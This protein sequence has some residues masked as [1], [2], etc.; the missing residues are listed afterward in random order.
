M[1]STTLATWAL[2]RGQKLARAGKTDEALAT[3]ESETA[4]GNY[5]LLIHHALTLARAGQADKALEQSAAAAAAAPE[6]GLPAVFNTYLLL[7]SG[8][9][10][11]AEAELNRA[12][13]LLP[14]NPIVSSLSAALDILRGNAVDGC[15]RLLEGPLTDNLDI[16][17]WIMAVVERRIFEA[18]GTDSGAIPPENERAPDDR[19]PDAV[20]ELS[21]GAYSR[22]GQ[23]LLEKGRPKSAL[24][25]LAR[26]AE[27]NPDDPALHATY[28]AALFEAGEFERAKTALARVPAKGPLA[29]VAQFYRAAAAY[30][31]GEYEAALHLLDTLPRTGDVVL[32]LEWCDYIRGMTLVA[33]GRPVEAAKHLAAFIDVEPG[34]APR[35]FAKALELLGGRT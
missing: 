24:K 21:A 14:L 22:K 27:L 13:G 5:R 12:K 6:D 3:F 26:A 8:R 1:A 18:A 16:L 20:P 29:G 31:L 32:Y 19:P 34:V 33:L 28:G 15:T 23:D 17:G 4:S 25:Y 10:E 7:R 2:G 11:Q 9:L 35:R 30:R